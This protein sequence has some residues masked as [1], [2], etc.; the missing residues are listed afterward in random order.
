[1]DIYSKKQRWKLLLLLSAVVIVGASLL[2][3]NQLVEKI[4]GEE[5]KKAALWADAIQKKSSLV[6]YTEDLFQKIQEDERRKVELWATAMHRLLTE[7][8]SNDLTFYVDIISSNKN[9]PIILTDEKDVVVSQVNLEKPVKVGEKMD[10]LVKVAFS[11]YEPIEVKYHNKTL[12]Y[13]YYQDSQIF[14]KLQQVLNDLVKTF[15]SEVVV[16]TASVPVIIMDSTQSKI[17]A[18]GNIDS[19]KAS[20]PKYMEAKRAAMAKEN[21]PIEIFLNNKTKNL[22][23]Y[24]DS[25]LLRQIKYYPIVQFGIIGLFL[26]VAYLAFSSARRSEQNQVW[27]GMAKETAHQLGTPLSSLIAWVE[28][29]KLKNVDESIISE[30]NKDVKRL[31]TITERFSK[32]GAEPKL[33]KTDLIKSLHDSVDYIKVRTSDK[34][35]FS[36]TLPEK[37]VSLPL[38]QQL[39]E[40][41]IEN[42][43][44]NAV[45]A[46]SGAGNID[47]TLHD[48][49]D[50]VYIDIQDTGKGISKSQYKSV[51]KP[52]FT[53]KHRGWGLGLSLSKRIIEVY[54]NGRIFVKQSAL[55]KG[56]TFR[57]VL[58]KF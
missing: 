16:N 6:I 28:Y 30:I 49:F 17:I 41:V 20:D 14:D 4:A 1:M 38:N 5:R 34:V 54:H 26:I 53:S 32:I 58:K 48:E 24:E 43:C 10:S 55:N 31:E 22:V 44:K 9:I 19:A 56:T 36:L 33:I 2:Y 40:W 42:L 50:L 8:N 51:F 13:L 12:N 7:N 37:D 35:V 18:F 39:F 15:F 46:M 27:A 57:I 29:L 45:D 21:K 25:F 3:T 47:I 11:K 23:F 52:G